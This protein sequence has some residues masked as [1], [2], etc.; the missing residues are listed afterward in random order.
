MSVSKHVSA[1]LLVIPD[2]ITVFIQIPCAPFLKI[3]A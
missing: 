3:P 1:K 2:G